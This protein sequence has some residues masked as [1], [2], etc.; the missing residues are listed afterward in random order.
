MKLRIIL[1]TVALI[2]SA[3]ALFGQAFIN[4]N[5]ESTTVPPGTPSGP[6]NPAMAFPDWTVGVGGTQSPNFTLYNSLTLG[7]VAQVLIGRIIR[8][9]ATHRCKDHTRHF[10]SSDRVPK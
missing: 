6:V 4:L 7:S 8:S 1:S 10:C 9:P 3:T 2:A 5:F